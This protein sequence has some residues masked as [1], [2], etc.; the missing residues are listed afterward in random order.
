MQC[1]AERNDRELIP[2]EVQRGL[3]GR[4]SPDHK[5]LYR[6][7]LHDLAEARGSHAW[8]GQPKMLKLVTQVPCASACSGEKIRPSMMRRSPAVT[9]GVISHEC[10]CRAWHYPAVPARSHQRS[11]QWVHSV[12]KLFSNHSDALPSACGQPRVIAERQ[13]DRR[14]MDAGSVGNILESGRAGHG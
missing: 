13:S 11:H 3:P 10:Q 14:A 6:A 12:A 7:R 2:S 8:L 9:S 4:H 5:P 1:L